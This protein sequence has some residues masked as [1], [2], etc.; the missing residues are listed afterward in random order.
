MQSSEEG[1]R[2]PSSSGKT[3]QDSQLRPP[4]NTLVIRRIHRPLASRRKRAGIER[5]AE[6]FYYHSWELAVELASIYSKNHC[7]SW[8]QWC[9]S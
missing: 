1:G 5:L 2:W 7:A 6:N 8:K 3:F 9:V 4:A